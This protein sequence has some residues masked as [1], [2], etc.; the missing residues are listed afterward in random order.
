MSDQSPYEILGVAEGASF[1]EIQSARTRLA[2]ECVN[3]PKRLQALEVAYDAVLMERLRLRQEGK[4][5]VPDG[6]RFAENKPVAKP[7]PPSAAMAPSS[8]WLR[9]LLSLP[10]SWE[11]LAPTVVYLGLMGLVAGFPTDQA[12]QVWSAIATGAALVFLYR[13]ERK[14]GR[15]ALLGFG[16][17]LVGVGIGSGV[18]YLLQQQFSHLPNSNLTISWITFGVLWLVSSFLK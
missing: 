14:L 17:L 2:Q 16:G 7:Q 10:D 11:M 9:R 13:K 8:Q 4:I 3:D 6:I 18:T 1:E 12:L 5:K 15:A